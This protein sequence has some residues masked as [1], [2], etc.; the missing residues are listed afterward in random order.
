MTIAETLLTR[1]DG[2]SFEVP[3]RAGTEVAKRVDRWSSPVTTA[4]DAR[5]VVQLDPPDKDNAWFLS[6]AGPDLDGQLVPLEVALIESRPKRHLAD[7]L[8]RLERLMPVLKRPGEARRGQ[9]VLSQDE[10]WELMTVVDR[11]PAA[12]GFDVRVPAL[13]RRKPSPA[14]RLRRRSPAIRQWSAPT[15]WRRSAGRRSST[16][17]S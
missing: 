3:T 9:V 4:S 2:S 5:L 10:A 1:L 14:L 15:S 11:W 12:A 7:E 17:W 6:V 8:A 13:S 16:T